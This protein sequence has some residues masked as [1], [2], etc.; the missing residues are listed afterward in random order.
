MLKGY[1]LQ[2]NLIVAN[3]LHIQ[4]R[5]DDA[6]ELY[7][8]MLPHCSDVD[9]FWNNR[10]VTLLAMGRFQE[11]AINFKRTLEIS[12]ELH[13]A[14][15]ALASCYQALGLFSQ[16]LDCCEKTILVEQNNA[17]AHWN[18]S[19]LLLLQGD[20]EKGWQE[21]EWRWNKKKF[22]SPKWD[23]AQPLWN[24]ATDSVST[25]MVHAEQGFGDTI[26]FCRYLPLIEESGVTTTFVCHP[27]LATLISSIS[28][29]IKIFAFGDELPAFDYHI[30]LMSLPGI[31]NTS[32]SNI[33][34]NIPYLKPTDQYL[35]KWNKRFDAIPGKKLNIGLCWSG[36]QYPDPL[37][38]IAPEKLKLLST[39]EGIN[40][41]SLQ[42][43]QQMGLPFEMQDM[44]AEIH[45]FSDTAALM[46]NLDIV[47]TIDTAVAH[48][49]G[50][51]GVKTWLLLPYIP[52]WRWL[53]DRNDSPWYPSM[54]ILRQN[55][56]GDWHA[57]IK[58]VANM[59]CKS[60]NL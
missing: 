45:N 54:T 1:E 17:E 22:T 20:F 28:P 46:M 11:A 53:L 49:A 3:N 6:L 34:A 50:A 7:D 2:Q 29:T 48:L 8:S 51:L 58:K 25:L 4:G 41:F 13:D 36:K 52:D 14:Q 38:S 43:D 59:L 60:N 16:A 5:F 56:P 18:K 10:G 26:Q 57:V 12:P 39:I 33:P 27:P 9:F 30:P 15:I 47:I 21:Y 35:K 44:T 23:L 32:L 31:F 42:I 24:G 19:L 55:S 40:W 37:R